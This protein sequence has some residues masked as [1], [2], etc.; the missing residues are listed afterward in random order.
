LEG[1]E[2]FGAGVDGVDLDLGI[3]AEELSGEAAVSVAEDQGV[4]AVDEF[5]EVVGSRNG[6]NVRYSSQR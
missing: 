5:V 6:P 1:C 4:A 2:H 3:R